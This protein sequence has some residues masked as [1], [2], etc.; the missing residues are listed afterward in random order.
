MDRNLN[1]SATFTNQ[2]GSGIGAASSM[3]HS[4]FQSSIKASSLLNSSLRVGGMA[5]ASILG[6]AGAIFAG[7]AKSGMEFE[8]QLVD[9]K[10]AGN[11]TTK[12][13]LTMGDSIK[14]ASV[15]FGEGRG[16][17]AT[18]TENFIKTSRNGAEAAKQVDFFSMMLK[19][20][21]VSAEEL[22]STLGDLQRESGATGKD[23]QDMVKGWYSATKMEGAETVWDKLLPSIPDL[24]SKFKA[25]NP[26]ADF[27][28]INK[29]VTASIFTTDPEAMK[30]A[31]DYMTPRL[32][33]DPRLLKELTKLGITNVNKASVLGVM[34]KVM[35]QYKTSSERGKALG[36]LF[37]MKTATSLM[38]LLEHW[39]EYQER[40]NKPDTARAQ[41]DAVTKA[42]TLG[43]KWKSLTNTIFNLASP[44]IMAA[45]D[46]ITNMLIHMTP[47]EMEAMKNGF[48]A[49]SGLI[50]AIGTGLS[51]LIG[52]LGEVAAFWETTGSDIYR[53][54]H[55]EYAAGARGPT[56]V[57][58]MIDPATGKAIPVET[59][60]TVQPTGRTAQGTQTG[61]TLE[62]GGPVFNVTAMFPGQPPV[63]ATHTEVHR[64]SN[65]GAKK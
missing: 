2:M 60:R 35:T 29:Y 45:V 4:F 48:Q 32:M 31:S 23:F 36:D 6:G 65:I 58:G 28:D 33:K 57:I 44:S 22:G 43:S 59:P 62:V 64:Q 37:G 38:P 10:V 52:K 19:N 18:L 56:K 47:E 16:D 53:L 63:T 27:K 25:A 40:L 24:V 51:A 12:E 9:I 30:R 49:I 61:I 13:M 39:A 1:I 21:N 5:M 20:S 41:A 34:E 46:K 15:T 54:F 14:E 50:I 3:L 55:P 8:K 11:L 42:G 17:I 7:F 26:K